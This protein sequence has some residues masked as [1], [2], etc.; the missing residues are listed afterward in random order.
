MMIR[1]RFCAALSFSVAAILSSSTLA[2]TPPAVDLQ[3]PQGSYPVV[4]AA[5][6]H[7]IFNENSMLQPP[8]EGGENYYDPS[9]LPPP[10]NGQPAF[11][12]PTYPGQ[13]MVSTSPGPAVPVP[14]TMPAQPVAPPLYGD[15]VPLPIEEVVVDNVVEEVAAEAPGPP[16]PWY[17]AGYWIG[18]WWDGSFEVG[19]N[20]SSGNADSLSLRTGFDLSRETERT[21]WD[22]DF[23]YSKVEA[24]QLETQHNALLFS[25]WDYKLANPRWSWFTK[26][27]L[28]YDEFKDFDLRVA[29][30]S[31]LGYLLIDTPKTQF[32][33][34]LGAGVSREIGGIDNE[35]KPEAVFGFDLEHKLSD[36]QKFTAVY[37]F[38]PNWSD[39]SDHRWVLDAGWEMVIDKPHNLSL[40]L[41]VIDRYDS[42]PNGAEANDINYSLLLLW[43][44]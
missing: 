41:G 33:P 17:T 28:E 13:P 42:T 21:D 14:G 27:S 37:D 9:S 25:T 35:Y 43:K 23:V 6:P 36:R 32:R 7:S 5:T 38:Y 19:I 1:M 40:K 10:F 29:L 22:I 15:G 2:Q 11:A 24:N 12:Q 30:N 31:G 18:P 4:S 16:P 20:G 44:I 39:F 26:L 3:L 8:A 34:R